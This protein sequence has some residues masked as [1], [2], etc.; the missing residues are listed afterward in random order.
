M[1]VLREAFDLVTIIE[2]NK[3]STEKQIKKIQ[4]QQK[5]LKRS[6]SNFDSFKR[7]ATMIDISKG[8][9]CLFRTI[10]CPLKD[11]CPKIKKPRWPTSNTKS[12]T[13]FG[14][15]CPFAHHPSELQFPES[16][17][18]K[19][20][21]NVHRIKNLE[22]KMLNNKPKEVFKPTGALFDCVGCN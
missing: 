11:K 15:E 18:T 22:Q 10:M 16:I 2:N 20:S 14:E 19:L 13:K 7:S 6:A 5:S 21:A 9:K 12:F 17:M 4:R 1:F 3:A 8:E